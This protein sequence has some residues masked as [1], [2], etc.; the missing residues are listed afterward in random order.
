MAEMW[1]QYKCY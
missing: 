1:S